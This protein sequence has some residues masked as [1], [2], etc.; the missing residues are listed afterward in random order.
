MDGQDILALVLVYLIIGAS[1]ALS[2]YADKRQFRFD[3]RKIVHIG[4]GNFVFVWWMFSAN[5][6]MLAF[7]A[8]PFAVILFLAMFPGN[9]VSDSKLGEISNDKGHRTGLFFYVVSINILVAFFFDHWAA[10]SIGIIA[11][12]YGDGFGSVI[13]RRFGKHK[14][15]NGKSLEGTVGMCLVTFIMSMV[16]VGAYTLFTNN[17]DLVCDLTPVISIWAAVAIVSVVA[18]VV[19]MLSPG[20]VDNLL[21]PLSVAVILVLL[22]L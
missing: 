7:F 1:L 6:I 18:C 21:I 4:V 5:W 11:M 17:F 20:Q 2:L 22:G 14:T 10:A 19:E 9:P 3:T 12:T 8:I 13:G 16:L 15:V